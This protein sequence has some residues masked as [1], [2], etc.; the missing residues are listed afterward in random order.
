MIAMGVFIGA[1]IGSFLPFL[2]VNVDDPNIKFRADFESYLMM[3]VYVGI[4]NI[5]ISLFLFKGKPKKGFGYQ[6]ELQN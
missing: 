3:Y 2:F 6:D 5:L 4:A 1:G